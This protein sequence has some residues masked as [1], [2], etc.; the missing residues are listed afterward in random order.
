[1]I[2]VLIQKRDYGKT[3][4]NFVL[5][6]KCDS[7]YCFINNIVLSSYIENIYNK[8]DDDIFLLHVVLRNI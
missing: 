6:E 2:I 3:W 8:S 4:K 1:M 7:F 5:N